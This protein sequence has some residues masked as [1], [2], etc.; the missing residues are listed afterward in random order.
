MIDLQRLWITVLNMSISASYVALGVM[1]IRFLLSRIRAPRIFA[2][3]LWAAV[4]IR[5]VVPVSFTASFSLLG[6]AR[7]GPAQ[8]GAT[9]DYVPYEL[10]LMEAPAV[11]VGAPALNDAVGSLLPR[12]SVGASVNPL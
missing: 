5:L 11:N 9:M 12:P 6:L 3:A 7:S 8:G 4:L 2:Y 10:G 1:L